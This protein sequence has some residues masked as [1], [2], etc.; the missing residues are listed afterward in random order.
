MIYIYDDN[1]DTYDKIENKSEWINSLLREASKGIKDVIAN[2]ENLDRAFEKASDSIRETGDA[3]K[4]GENQDK[5]FKNIQARIGQ[6]FGLASAFTV[7][8]QFA[9]KSA[10]TIRDLDAAFTQIAVVS[11]KTTQQL[12]G[13]FEE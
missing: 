6:I 1:I 2:A 11:E 9:I 5:F 8:R 13:S 3:I 12:W 4:R 10:E 7:L